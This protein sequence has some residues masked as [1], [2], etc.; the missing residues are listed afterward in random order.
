M[1]KPW[2]KVIEEEFERRFGLQGRADRVW[3]LCDAA[4]DLPADLHA[5][6]T[7]GADAG[8]RQGDRARH[9]IQR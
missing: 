3:S 9:V 2:L 6:G 4:S 8:A 5:N 7:D 1:A